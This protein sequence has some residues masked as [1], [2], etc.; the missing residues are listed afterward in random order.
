MP[1]IVSQLMSC[2]RVLGAE[3]KDVL[4]RLSS[5]ATTARMKKH[6]GHSGL[7]EE[8]IL[9]V[10]SGS[11]L[12]SQ[13]A[14]LS[15]EPLMGALRYWSLEG[16]QLDLGWD[17]FL[18]ITANAAAKEC[19]FCGWPLLIW[20]HGIM[21]RP[22]ETI[23]GPRRA[24]RGAKGAGSAAGGVGGWVLRVLCPLLGVLRHLGRV[25]VQLRNCPT[26]VMPSPVTLAIPDSASIRRKRAR[27]LSM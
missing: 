21:G 25:L 18:L 16:S 14:L 15:S 3:D 13:Q 20:W 9:A 19:P 11:Q 26:F 24:W 10:D 7:K 27:Q 2:L 1:S 23:A 4:C 8:S 12:D 5:S 22:E 17:D 6:I